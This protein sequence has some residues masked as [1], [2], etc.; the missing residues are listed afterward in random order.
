MALSMSNLT[1]LVLKGLA[2]DNIL[3]V[4][5]KSCFKLN[6]LDISESYTITNIG[7]KELLQ[8]EIDSIDEERLQVTTGI[9]WWQSEN[10]FKK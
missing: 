4:I 9:P 10:I 3:K 7:V 8:I 5:G 2:C 1:H 6:L